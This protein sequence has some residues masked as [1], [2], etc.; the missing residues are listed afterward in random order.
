MLGRLWR[1]GLRR[2]LLGGSRPWFYVMVGVGALRVAR[3]L[4]VRSPKTVYAEELRPGESVLIS[5]HADRT[6]GDAR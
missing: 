6:L 4:A 2:G 5:H 3:R 1:T